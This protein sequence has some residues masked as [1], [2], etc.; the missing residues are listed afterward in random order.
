MLLASPAEA[1]QT[2]FW[3]VLYVESG[4]SPE[5]RI[6][7]VYPPE[8][9]DR[10]SMQLRTTP[11]PQKY[12]NLNRFKLIDAIIDISILTKSKY[13]LNLQAKLLVGRQ[14]TSRRQTPEPW[15]QFTEAFN[16][17]NSYADH[18]SWYAAAFPAPDGPK[19]A[20]YSVQGRDTGRRMRASVRETEISGVVS[21]L[22]AIEHFWQDTTADR[23][24]ILQREDP[25]D[26]RSK[27]TENEGDIQPRRL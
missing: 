17:N 8:R 7:D 21:Y 11:I 12:Y 27:E 23:T 13:T 18:I 4:G 24:M 25:H 22:V 16:A 19:T 6:A 2:N 1:D 15:C 10:P 5:L 20:T 14:A 9:F 3:F 26:R